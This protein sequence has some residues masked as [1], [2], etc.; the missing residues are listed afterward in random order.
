MDESNTKIQAYY[1]LPTA[2]LNLR[3]NYKLRMASRVFAEVYRHDSLGAFYRMWT[4]DNLKPS[5]RKAASV[6]DQ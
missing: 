5:H 1:L 3:M 2:H 6:T 4:R